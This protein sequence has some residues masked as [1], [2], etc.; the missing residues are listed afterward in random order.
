MLLIRF[1]QL[2]K[3]YLL[4]IP[5]SLYYNI[6][7]LGIRKGLRCPIFFSNTTSITIQ[8]A[9]VDFKC[10]I[11]TGMLKIG[12]S[13]C[14]FILEQ[15]DK[16]TFTLDHSKLVLHGSAIFGAGCRISISNGATLS[17]GCNV[18]CTGRCT[19]LCRESIEL[20]DNVVT[21]WDITLMDH[22]AHKIRT[23]I[24]NTTKTDKA[25]I[26]IGHHVWLAHSCSVK[27]GCQIRE[28]S[29]IGSNSVV[30]KS[31]E[32]PYALYCGIPVR[33]IRRDIQW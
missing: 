22:D 28:G 20:K 14:D 24:D 4:S 18:W 7:L 5:R 31:L 15:T 30:T 9:S 26:C 2:N 1:I 3:N 17:L 12:F 19:I 32:E 13:T 27:K 21:A 10:S 11:S 29:I 8:K 6:R 25:P 16:S 33:L 23:G